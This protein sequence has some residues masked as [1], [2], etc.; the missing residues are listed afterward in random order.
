MKKII[1]SMIFCAVAFV[2]KAQVESVDFKTNFRSDLGVGAGITA[3]I[4]KDFEFSPSADFY[5]WD[6]GNHI[7]FEADFHYKIDLGKNF[8]L[9]P[10]A[11]GVL[12]YTN[13]KDGHVCKHHPHAHPHDDKYYDG[14]TNFG[15]NIGC[16][17]KYDFNKK[18]AGFIDTKYQWINEED[19]AYD[20]T[21]LS[22]GVK[23]AI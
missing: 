5:F 3:D 1:L 16:G 23:F 2:A 12:C 22:I 17:I 10:I 7:D 21:Y 18:I 15:I 20:E 6:C 11:G 4:G 19:H 13:L 14:K 8:T 9:Y